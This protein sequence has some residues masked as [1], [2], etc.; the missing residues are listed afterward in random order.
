M[1][2]PGLDRPF[3]GIAVKGRGD[4]VVSPTLFESRQIAD[5]T[6]IYGRFQPGLNNP[7]GELLNSNNR[8][9]GRLME[10]SYTKAVGD[11][12][13]GRL[14]GSKLVGLLWVD[15]S[16]QAALLRFQWRWWVKSVS[17]GRF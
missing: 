11:N 1:K 5:I 14:P 7:W 9:P 10:L 8:T 4:N 15:K 12:D 13:K 16:R 3:R 17:H 2:C 6:V